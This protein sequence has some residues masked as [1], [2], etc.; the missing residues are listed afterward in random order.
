MNERNEP[1]PRNE[2]EARVARLLHEAPEPGADPEYR[3]RLREDFVTGAIEVRGTREARERARR[4]V[5][6]FPGG[7][8]KVR[9]GF[10]IAAAVAT[11]AALAIVV[12]TLN[13]GPRWWIAGV[14]GEGQAM[15]DGRPIAL[16]DREALDRAIK[17]GVEI[18]LPAG[19]GIDLC[20]NGVLG[21]Q[22]TERARITIPP[23]PHR[24]F[25]RSTEMHIRGGEVRFATGVDFHG[26]HLKIHTREAAVEVVGTTFA[27]IT[28]SNG[29]CVCVLDGVAKV[30]RL[31]DEKGQD[32]VPVPGG[33]L[34][35]VYAD[36]KKPMALDDMRPWERG[37]LSNFRD[38]MRPWLVEG[39]KEGQQ[40]VD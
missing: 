21:M 4:P 22:L 8:P 17:P 20:S 10:W 24:W 39:Y 2:Q 40:D 32:M 25:G 33:R 29:T 37:L 18:E 7:S 3:A 13:Q 36:E 14:R 12:G 30:G 19:A 34:R 23:P 16:S 6:R 26:A 5:V 35:F 1:K 31:V 27:V 11:A 38:S 9:T 15:I 28:Q